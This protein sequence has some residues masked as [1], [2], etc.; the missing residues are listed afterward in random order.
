MTKSLAIMCCS[1]TLSISGLGQE[2]SEPTLEQTVE[3]S[4][5]GGHTEGI[6]IKQVRRGGDSSAAALARVI[7]DRRLDDSQIEM[8]AFLL[9][10]AFSQP[11]LI[12]NRGDREPRI[13]LLLLKYF[14]L[15]TGDQALRDKIE[16]TRE[17]IVGHAPGPQ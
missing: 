11:N 3:R 2:R 7:S 17:N 8:A 16:H 14:E 10:A 13:A 6:G 15:A 9:G 12:E 5:F 1:L 4:V